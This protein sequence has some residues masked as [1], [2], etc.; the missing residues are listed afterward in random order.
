MWN[1]S[2]TVYDH[3]MNPRNARAM[4]NANAVAEVGSLACGDALK[5]YLKINEHDI[6]EDASFQTFGC[7]SAIASSS[8]LTELIKGKSVDE[9]AHIT[10]RDI[11]EA[12]GGLP[13]AKMHCSVMGQEALEAAINNWRGI[14]NKGHDEGTIVCKCFGVSDE[15]IRH[16]VRE[17]GLT[18]VEQITEYTKAGGGCGECRCA[19]QRI[20]DEEMA[21]AAS[22]EQKAFANFTKGAHSDPNAQPASNAHAATV[23]KITDSASE[24]PTHDADTATVQNVPLAERPTQV[25]RVALRNIR[26]LG[27]CRERGNNIR[28]E[29]G[30]DTR[31]NS[32]K[33]TSSSCGGH[34]AHRCGAGCSCKG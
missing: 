18:S 23:G 32:E 2:D 34:G 31:H 24:H 15:H 9:A 33:G 11:A 22:P 17:N 8:M 30:G 10:N 3:F 27:L 13:Q 4:E 29:R 20:L 7:A 25:R 12:L 21:A 1:Y 14:E 19:L 26:A 28:S 5:L 6:I 16:A